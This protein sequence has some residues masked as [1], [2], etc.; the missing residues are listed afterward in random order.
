MHLEAAAAG[1]GAVIED[2][3]RGRGQ[4]RMR[5]VGQA[6]RV[7]WPTDAVAEGEAELLVDVCVAD[8][9]DRV[10]LDL[11]RVRCSEVALGEG[12]VPVVTR[13]RRSVERLCRLVERRAAPVLAGRAVLDRDVH[14][15]DTGSAVRNGP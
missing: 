13:K 6:E 12:I 5:R 7:G 4:V 1:R 2:V 11:V 3:R 14:L 8:V 15:R 9:V 10:D